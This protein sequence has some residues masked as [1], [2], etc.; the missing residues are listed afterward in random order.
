MSSV[1]G[2]SGGW[3]NLFPQEPQGTGPLLAPRNDQKAACLYHV[4]ATSPGLRPRALRGH[5]ALERLSATGA[6]PG[7]PQ[8]A[9]TSTGYKL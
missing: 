9:S 5:Y 6:C 1:Q 2:V 3:G 7:R 4:G 8:A